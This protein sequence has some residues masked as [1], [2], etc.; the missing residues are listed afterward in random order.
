MKKR[1]DHPLS[2]QGL[3]VYAAQINRLAIDSA[4][5]IIAHFTKKGR[6]SLKIVDMTNTLKL[7]YQ[8]FYF[9]QLIAVFPRVI[10]SLSAPAPPLSPPLIW[11]PTKCSPPRRS[12][13]G[14]A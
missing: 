10:L 14:A 9:F 3:Q 2:F 7:S 1:V 13:G 5:I 4:V 8:L 11:L 6:A 12:P